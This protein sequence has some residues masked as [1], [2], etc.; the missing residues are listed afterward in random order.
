M[1]RQIATAIVYSNLWIAGGAAALT[2]QTMWLYQLKPDPLLVAFVFLSTWATYNFQRLLRFNK[3]WLRA[4]TGRL[5]WLVQSRKSL[6]ILTLLAL[7]G[8][9][10]T[11]LFTLKA[12]DLWVLVPTGLV[13]VLYAYPFL[14]FRGRKGALRD[15]PGMKIFWIAGSWTVVT[16]MLPLLRDGHWQTAYSWS[17]LERFLFILAITL[18]FDV[19]DLAYDPPDQRTIPQIIGVKRSAW[20]ALLFNTLFM[21]TV[22]FNGWNSGY[23]E[24]AVM[25]LLVSGTFN[26][27]ALAFAFRVRKETYYSL[28]LDGL[29]WLQPVL[30]F[31]IM[32]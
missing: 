6:I 4:R 26:I 3:W 30:V 11:A 15:I 24:Q 19:R 18:P 23:G 31:L 27:A 32:R 14:V 12:N 17:M 25:A 7:T 10:I 28:I 9:S 1:L 2:A 21:A 29:T 22:L 5:H 13:A 16:V 20:L 8:A